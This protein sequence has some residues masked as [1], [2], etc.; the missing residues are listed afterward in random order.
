MDA[1][2]PNWQHAREPFAAE[3]RPAVVSRTPVG[4]SRPLMHNIYHEASRLFSTSYAYHGNIY[5]E[6]MHVNFLKIS[7]PA[8]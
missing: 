6:G 4:S 2:M 1:F 8:R 3:C 5:H 7:R